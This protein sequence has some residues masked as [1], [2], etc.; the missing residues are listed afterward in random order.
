MYVQYYNNN[1]VFGDYM[2]LDITSH[3]AL[4]YITH[5]NLIL[6]HTVDGMANAK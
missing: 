3:A 4:S 6:Q 2:T 1:A 5:H